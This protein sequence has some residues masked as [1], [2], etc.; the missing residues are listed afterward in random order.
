L[1]ER[2]D[3][4]NKTVSDRRERRVFVV[5]F[6]QRR[7]AEGNKKTARFVIPTTGKKTTAE[8]SE[9]WV[10]VVGLPLPENQQS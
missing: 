2:E 8:R 4:E 6:P 9:A 1:L 3:G 10:F 7:I 5:G